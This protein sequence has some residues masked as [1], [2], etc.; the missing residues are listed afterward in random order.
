MLDATN[1]YHY[2]LYSLY[3]FSLA[4]SPTANFG[5]QRNLQIS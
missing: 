1:N 3:A 4:K 5:N 2:T